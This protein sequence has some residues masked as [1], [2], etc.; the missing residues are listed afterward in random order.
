MVKRAEVD[1][2]DEARL[3]VHRLGDHDDRMHGCVLEVYARGCKCG[4]MVGCKS[5]GQVWQLGW[6]WTFNG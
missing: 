1:Y 5:H 2:D 6:G 4:N 3:L